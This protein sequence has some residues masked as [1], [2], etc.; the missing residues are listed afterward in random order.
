[1]HSRSIGIDKIFTHEEHQGYLG[2]YVGNDS[3]KVFCNDMRNFCFC[4]SG[5]KKKL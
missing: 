1:M 4:L 2:R 3:L 5:T